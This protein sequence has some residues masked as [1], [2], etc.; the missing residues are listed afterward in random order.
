MFD[1]LTDSVLLQMSLFVYVV[2]VF[3]ATIHALFVD[4]AYVTVVRMVFGTAVASGLLYLG[5][6]MRVFH[7]VPEFFFSGYLPN[8]PLTALSLSSFAIAVA[9]FVLSAAVRVL[10]NILK[11]GEDTATLQYSFQLAPHLAEAP[12]IHF[13]HAK[14]DYPRFRISYIYP[15]HAG[16]MFLWFDMKKKMFIQEPVLTEREWKELESS[17]ASIAEEIDQAIADIIKS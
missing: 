5:E 10:G 12:H 16:E 14:G 17:A 1:F 6:Y 9:L 11:G 15:E 4:R 8:H 3:I 7:K 13:L 2:C